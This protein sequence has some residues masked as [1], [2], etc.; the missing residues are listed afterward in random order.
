MSPSLGGYLPPNAFSALSAASCCCHGQLEEPRLDP[1]SRAV[2]S[3]AEPGSA[4]LHARTMG[5]P[6]RAGRF[7]TRRIASLLRG[8]NRHSNRHKAGPQDGRLGAKTPEDFSEDFCP[9]RRWR[10]GRIDH[11]ARSTAWPGVATQAAFLRVSHQSQF[12]KT[13]S[14][15]IRTEEAGKGRWTGEIRAKRVAAHNPRWW[16]GRVLGRASREYC[17]AGRSHGARDKG[18]LR[19]CV[20]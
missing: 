7:I 5:L 13:Q 2:T 3:S 20:G 17:N 1:V 10:G 9:D 12:V 14:R 19:G 18:R 11:P 4:R 15:D 6:P 16:R 8:L